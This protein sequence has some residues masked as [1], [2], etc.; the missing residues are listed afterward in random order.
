MAERKAGDVTTEETPRTC[1]PAGTSGA[2][3]SRS[4]HAIHANSW[5]KKT[6]GMNLT[7]T[8]DPLPWFLK[9]NARSAAVGW[10]P[11]PTNPAGR[12]SLQLDG[13]A[14]IVWTPAGWTC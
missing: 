12:R 8:H 11:Q 13:I 5:E 10:K 6:L 1:R 9:K 7:A 14:S 3:A 2:F 4:S